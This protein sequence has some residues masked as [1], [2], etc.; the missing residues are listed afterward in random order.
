M[1]K[2][3][4]TE[5]VPKERGDKK[6]VPLTRRW[7]EEEEEEVVKVVHVAS[8]KTKPR[9]QLVGSARWSVRSMSAR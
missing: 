1:R 5:R 7:R 3:R 6:S 8:K 4:K 2:D 9:K